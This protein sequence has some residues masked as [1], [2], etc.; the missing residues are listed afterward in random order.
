MPTSPKRTS[1]P[2]VLIVGAGPTGLTLACALARGGVS[3]RLLDAAPHPPRGSRGKGVQPRTLELF[4]D[5][6]VVARVLAHG[7]L[8]MPIRSTA[9]DGQVTLGGAIPEALQ[10]RPDVPYPASLTTPQWRTEAALRA[11]LSELG[12][13]VEF[14]TALQSFEA[15]SDGVSAVLVRRGEAETVSA[16]W[17]VGCDGGHSIVRK[18]AAI[19]FEGETREDV[20]MAVA[21]VQID[22]LARDAWQ[23]WR[24]AE[25]A[26][27]LCPLPSTDVFQ[28]QASIAPGQDPSL[29]RPHLQAMLERRTR[30]NDLR[31]HEPEWSSLW[32]SNT[33]LAAR[34]RAGNVFLAGDAAHVHS[35]AGGQGMNTGIQDAYDLA[36][37]LCAVAHGASPTLLDSY[38]AERRP[39][40][41]HV[42]ALSNAR[43]AQALEAKNLAPRRDA[44]TLQLDVGYR[45]SALAVDDRDDTASLRA[46]DRAPDATRLLTAAGERRLFELIGG[47]RFTLLCFGATPPVPRRVFDVKTLAVVERATRPEH[48]VDREGQL[49]HAYGATERTLVLIRPD[50]YVGLISDAGEP[51]A[52]ARYLDALR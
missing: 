42:L 7:Q 32:R 44:S 34:Y 2:M 37:K 12:S 39:V 30:R 50:G 18:S 24:H 16:R 5:L 25:G 1:P 49:A 29:S 22:G 33:R 13:A 27:A 52:L 41:T 31:L 26:L 3:H 46:G 20:Q 28:Y 48:L 36:W 9:A 10:G 38:E 40:A 43:L 19:P 11:R 21:D 47:G 51:R 15:T 35:P 8:A 45:G 17:L 14:G 23:L 6:G 4:E